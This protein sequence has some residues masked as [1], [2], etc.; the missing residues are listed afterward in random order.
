MK[1][2]DIIGQ[3]LFETCKLS[4]FYLN[5][6]SNSSEE[7][8]ESPMLLA[9]AY[10]HKLYEIVERYDRLLEANKQRQQLTLS[11]DT[12]KTATGSK[13]TTPLTRTS[14]PNKYYPSSTLSSS[15]STMGH[16]AGGSVSTANTPMSAVTPTKQQSAMTPSQSSQS[17][18]KT[19]LSNYSLS[20]NKRFVV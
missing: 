20:T 2:D 13:A 19:S 10:K 3:K 18:L 9:A 17:F 4:E 6:I 14:T 16:F 7:D 5:L 11:F 15:N 1:K 8:Q 12:S